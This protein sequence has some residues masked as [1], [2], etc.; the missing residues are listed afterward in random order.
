[1]VLNDISIANNNILLKMLIK[2]VTSEGIRSIINVFVERSKEEAVV[3]T[4]ERSERGKRD[5][6]R[7]KEEEEEG[8]GEDVTNNFRTLS[9][10]T[11]DGK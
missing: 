1:L 9:S 4:G 10:G 7:E 6:R 2:K 8:E 3:W 11:E 5:K